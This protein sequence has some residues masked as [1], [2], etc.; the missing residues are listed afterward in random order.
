[1]YSWN[2]SSQSMLV[3]TSTTSALSGLQSSSDVTSLSSS[4]STNHPG[5]DSEGMRSED[6]G[7]GVRN[8]LVSKEATVNN[9][10]GVVHGSGKFASLS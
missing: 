1:M 7:E 2:I 10:D 5:G 4:L 9:G 6:V 8:G 3:A